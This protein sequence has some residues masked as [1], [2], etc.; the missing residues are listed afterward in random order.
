MSAVFSSTTKVRPRWTHLNLIR[1]NSPSW[2]W[3]CCRV[4]HSIRITRT[5]CESASSPKSDRTVLVPI[6]R[7]LK[8]CKLQNVP[9][10]LGTSGCIFFVMVVT[11]GILFWRKVKAGQKVLNEFQ[12][13]TFRY[14]TLPSFLHYF[15]L[16]F[17]WLGVPIIFT[18][19]TS[20]P[21]RAK[22][23]NKYW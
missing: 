2:Q 8:I 7:P 6:A 4:T 1:F 13:V 3:N 17:I 12:N 20:E 22:T 11:P 5:P 23:W 16:S 9:P 15:F 10:H 18:S 19:K 21:F 14:F